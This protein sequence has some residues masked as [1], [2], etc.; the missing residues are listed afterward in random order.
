MNFDFRY[1]LRRLIRA[2]GFTL[3]A[4]L[5]IA[6]GVGANTA[7]FS[8]VNAV[9][10]R[11]PVAV[12]EP[13][14]LVGVFTSDYSGPPFGIVLRRGPVRLQRADCRRLRRGDGFLAAARGRRVGRQP[15]ARRRRGRHRQLF[16]GARHAARRGPRVWRRAARAG[17]RASGGDLACALAATLRRRSCHRR[18]AAANERAR[19]HDHRRRSGRLR[20]LAARSRC[21]C[22]GAGRDRRLRRD[23]AERLHIAAAIV[24]RSVTHGSSLA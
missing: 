5:T 6:L 7:I 24:A 18:Q 21:R 17:R 10:L 15:R 16:P 4:A 1:A 14:R 20:G 3:A 13:D 11:P 22:L 8:L 19:V 12:A 2:R 9:L 23:G